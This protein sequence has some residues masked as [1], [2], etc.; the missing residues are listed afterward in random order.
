LKYPNIFS[1]LQVKGMTLK[2][3]IIMP[4]MGTN[5]ATFNGEVSETMMNY[6]ELRAKGGTALIIVENACVDFPMGTNGTK[7]LR[8]DDNQFV[9]GLYELV[10]RIHAYDAKASIQLNHAGASAYVARLGGKQPVSASNIPSK[11]NGS[12][13]RE[14]KVEEIYEIAK[15]YGEAAARAQLAGFDSVEIHG[16][17][18]Y[19]ICQFMSP[20]YNKRTDE[21]GGS[22]EN[23]ARFASL[24]LDSV[25]AAVGPKFPISFRISAD[26]FLEGGN[27]LE[28]TL[29]IMKYLVE[30]I[31]II[32]VSAAENDSIQY[33]I[34]KMDLADGWRSYLGKAFKEKFNKPVVVSGNIRNPQIAEEIIARGDA[35]LIAIGR[36]LI[37]EPNWVNKIARG[38]EKYLRKCISCNIGCADHRIGRSQPV[39][40]TINPDVIFED[41]YKKNHVKKNVNV[42]VI[43]AGSAGME[44][45]C[46]AAEVGCNVTLLE[47]KDRVGG[48]CWMIGLIPS[49]KRIHDFVTYLENRMAKLPNL[50]LKLNTKATRELLDKLNP[51][52][53]VNATGSKPLLPPIP[54]LCDFV[55]QEGSKI[56]SIFGFLNN[57]KSFENSKGRKIVVVGGGAVGLDVA[58]FFAEHEADVTIVEMMPQL[59]KDLDYIT[60]ISMFDIIKKHNIKVLTN[61]A[62][63]RVNADSFTVKNPDGSI[64]DLK[65]DYG[66][67]CLGMRSEVSDYKNLE[68]YVQEKGIKLYNIG[69]S[70]RV[71]KIINGVEEGRNVVKILEVMGAF[72]NR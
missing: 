4:P 70:K 62:L 5:Y 10:E 50:T 52:L 56:K 2:N 42:V 20:L 6:Y 14:L 26:D 30:K 38:E 37:S 44:A 35:D 60:K 12:I 68:N 72:T 29:E 9:P 23:R 22:I 61:T 25:R 17:H 65:F 15:K 57:V 51:D 64:E 71:R 67:V 3:R 18:S 59:A 66:F 43:G 13:P 40:C 24:V 39:R 46:T 53:V 19:L 63:Q 1:P 41:A 49:K 47:E 11:T 21:F 69:D 33:Q 28:D 54:G 8:I 7:Q 31:D 58:E 36:G 32:N 48:L 34:D 45:A 27:T 16:G 55:D